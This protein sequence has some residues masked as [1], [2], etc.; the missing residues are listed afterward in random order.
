MVFLAG[1]KLTAGRLNT[2]IPSVEDDEYQQA[3]AAQ[4]TSSNTYTSLT[5]DPAITFVVPRSG[6]VWLKWGATTICGDATTVSLMSVEVREGG[7]IGAGTIVIA[8]DDNRAIP[9]EGLQDENGG[10]EYLAGV[11]ESLNPG[12]TYNA[13][14]TYR[15]VSGVSTCTFA[16]RWVG[17]TSAQ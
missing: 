3:S 9:H 8:S 5:G 16:R 17:A 14:C 15:R 10:F 7:T 6:K 4:A 11:N 13:R 12:A 1:E 2:E